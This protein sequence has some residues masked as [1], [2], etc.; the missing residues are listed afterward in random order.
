MSIFM[1]ANEEIIRENDM[2][3]WKKW[4]SKKENADISK[5]GAQFY[6]TSCKNGA[7]QTMFY[8]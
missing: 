3:L 1:Y 2:Q 5:E 4:S 7:L 6:I 8:K